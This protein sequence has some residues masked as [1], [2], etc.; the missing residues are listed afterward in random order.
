MWVGSGDRLRKKALRCEGQAGWQGRRER[1][2]GKGRGMG[3]PTSSA[4]VWLGEGEGFGSQKA[5]QSK[6]A[7]STPS[8]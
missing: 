7:W 6:R 2:L 4:Q 5:A 1:E 8:W 3:V